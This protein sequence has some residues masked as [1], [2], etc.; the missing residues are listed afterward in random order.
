MGVVWKLLVL[1][2]VL[3]MP[4]GMAPA[5]AAPLHQPSAGMPMRHCPDQGAN[6]HMKGGFSECTMACAAALSAADLVR[7]EPLPITFVPDASTMQQVLHGLHPDIATP[8]PKTS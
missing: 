8:P 4:I 5:A 1:V 2:A 6:H 7:T 3:M